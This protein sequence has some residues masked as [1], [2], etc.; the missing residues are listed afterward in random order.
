MLHVLEM[1]KNLLSA[2][3]FRKG[4]LGIHLAK[5]IFIEDKEGN[6]STNLIEINGFLKIGQHLANNRAL[7]S[8]L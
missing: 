6:K 1:A 7:A 5:E 2:Q 8:Y 4:G 3:E